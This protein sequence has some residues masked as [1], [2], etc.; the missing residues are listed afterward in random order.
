MTT[1]TRTSQSLPR[2]QTPRR[3]PLVVKGHA[4]ILVGTSFRYWLTGF[5]TGDLSYW[6]RAF[7]LSAKSLGT[8]QARDVCSE[9]SRWVRVLSDRSRR[10]IRVLSPDATQYSRDECVAMAV[11]AS[12][13]HRACPALQACAITLLGCEPSSEVADLS[14]AVADRLTCAEQRLSERSMEYVVRHSA[15]GVPLLI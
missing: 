11:I 4:E 9:F 13:Q 7:D 6:Q 15:P 8:E 3:S 5:R 1:H 12:Y 14:C 10:D 2:K